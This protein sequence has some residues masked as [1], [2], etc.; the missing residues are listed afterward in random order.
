LFFLRPADT[1]QQQKKTA[2]HSSSVTAQHSHRATRHVMP[3]SSFVA[4]LRLVL[5]D[6]TQRWRCDG[7]RGRLVFLHIYRPPLPFG[8][9]LLVI[10]SWIWFVVSLTY[11]QPVGFWEVSALIVVLGSDSDS[12][13][14]L[15][16]P[17][18]GRLFIVDLDF[19]N[20][21]NKS[22]ALALQDSRSGSRRR[23]KLPGMA[24]RKKKTMERT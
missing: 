9:G 18:P 8:A 3:S 5:D 6:D 11:V 23:D 12:R 17:Y 16:I 10:T 20:I 13:V 1:Y 24:R 21:I 22:M 15:R 7:V 2:P 19:N 14:V 4:T